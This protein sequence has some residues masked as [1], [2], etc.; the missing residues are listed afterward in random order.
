MV[1][2]LHYDGN[3]MCITTISSKTFQRLAIIACMIRISVMASIRLLVSEEAGLEGGWVIRGDETE[4]V[5]KRSS[6][7]LSRRPL[8][9]SASA[10]PCSFT[11]CEGLS[12][13]RR[14]PLADLSN[15]WC[16]FLEASSGS[17]LSSSSSS[18]GSAMP[19][20]S[21]KSSLLFLG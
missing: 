2:D 13:P 10:P 3:L 8:L 12:W 21:S 11:H 5:E 1:S 7:R 14:T 20:M 15:L 9:S 16:H 18:S 6:S 19:I 17:S 4:D